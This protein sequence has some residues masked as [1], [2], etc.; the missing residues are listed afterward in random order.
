MCIVKTTSELVLIRSENEIYI[1]SMRF[2]KG[3]QTT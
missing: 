1:D 2:K 3:K